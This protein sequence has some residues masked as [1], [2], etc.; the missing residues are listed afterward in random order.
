M[1]KIIKGFSITGITLLA[2]IFLLVHGCASVGNQQLAK[3]NEKTVASKIT[4]GVSTKADVRAKFG[5]P[6]KTSF[7]DSGLEIWTYELTD[8]SADAVSYIPLVNWFG[9]SASGTQ[10]ELVVLFKENGTV[11]RYSM[12][13][14]DVQKKSGIF[15]N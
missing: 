10:K 5:S 12:S 6:L 9:H 2:L 7:T 11:K 14:S 8:V 3:E 4:E 1:L 15:N 13:V